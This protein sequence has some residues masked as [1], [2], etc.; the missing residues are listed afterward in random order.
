MTRE[1]IRGNWSHCWGLSSA[2]CNNYTNSSLFVLSLKCSRWQS[3]SIQ[4][5]LPLVYRNVAP[6]WYWLH[7][8]IVSCLGYPSTDSPQHLLKKMR[9]CFQ[10]FSISFSFSNAQ[11]WSKLTSTISQTH[12]VLVSISWIRK[13][14]ILLSMIQ[15]LS[16]WMVLNSK[17]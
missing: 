10:I 16:V 2:L 9:A 8:L 12:F 3:W 17:N 6:S 13:S 1:N 4:A 15:T 11:N 14:S 5:L 7:S